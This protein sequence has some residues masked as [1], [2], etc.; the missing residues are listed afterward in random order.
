MDQTKSIVE[1][2]FH[3]ILYGYLYTRTRQD[4]QNLRVTIKAGMLD[5]DMEPQVLADVSI[6]IPDDNQT[7]DRIDVALND[8]LFEGVKDT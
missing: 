1:A 2:T 7:T 5:N 6:D 3:F 4:Y 8:I